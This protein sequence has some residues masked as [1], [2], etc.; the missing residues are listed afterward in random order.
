MISPVILF[1]FI[2]GV[3][4]SF[5]VFTPAYV[6]T[7]GGPQ[8][9]SYFF[10]Y[11]LYLHAFGYFEMGVASALAWVLFVIIMILSLILFKGGE[12]LVYYESG[13]AFR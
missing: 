10:V 9:A 11:H 2:T 13:G 1:T 7:Q 12:R 3:I 8:Y 5:Q 6:I 4:G